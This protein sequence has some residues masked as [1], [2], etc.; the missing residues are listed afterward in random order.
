ML[1]APLSKTQRMW[2][3]CIVEGQL[4]LFL[5]LPA[6]SSTTLMTGMSI[7]AV[8]TGAVTPEC[9]GD[10]KSKPLAL[11]AEMAAFI[12]CAVQTFWTKETQYEYELLTTSFASMAQ[13]STQ[14]LTHPSRRYMY[15]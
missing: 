14:T 8:R 2:G 1:P 4:R 10:Q 7:I 3:S 13:L 5:Q 15:T 6:I 9:D 11:L 12:C